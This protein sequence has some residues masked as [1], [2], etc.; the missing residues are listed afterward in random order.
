M[1]AS[2]SGLSSVPILEMYSMKRKRRFKIDEGQ[3]RGNAEFMHASSRRTEIYQRSKSLTYHTK[4]PREGTSE[5]VAFF[6]FSI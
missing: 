3:H 6:A 4:V 2:E 5:I 1:N